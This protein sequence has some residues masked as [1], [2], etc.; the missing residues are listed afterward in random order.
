M[1]RAMALLVIA[2][3]T[4]AA[5]VTSGCLLNQDTLVAICCG[6]ATNGIAWGSRHD[7]RYH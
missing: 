3:V 6:T 1:P 2:H 7:P 5:V 4:N